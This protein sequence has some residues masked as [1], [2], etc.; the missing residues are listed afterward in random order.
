MSSASQ[1]VGNG[2]EDGRRDQYRQMM[3]ALEQL[4]GRYGG[5]RGELL[6]KVRAEFEALEPSK[7][8]TLRVV[9]P[10]VTVP[11]SG[12]VSKPSQCR[13]CGRDMRPS[14]TAGTLVCQNGHTRI[15]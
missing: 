7:S 4:Q 9:A 14:D 13:A 3:S 2:Y 10:P 11:S 1:R 12:P 6:A 8:T 15:T 5:V